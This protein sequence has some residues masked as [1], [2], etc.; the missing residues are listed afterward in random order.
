MTTYNMSADMRSR[1]L[2]E[3]FE[4]MRANVSTLVSD[5]Q[6]QHDT[7]ESLDAAVQSS[8]RVRAAHLAKMREMG[9]LSGQIRQVLEDG[10]RT[11]IINLLRTGEYVLSPELAA[12]IADEI[13]A[14]NP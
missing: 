13:I 2:A 11:G 4:Q 10:N 5:E 8:V 14:Q 9:Q 7:V 12:E 1:A 3:L 6:I